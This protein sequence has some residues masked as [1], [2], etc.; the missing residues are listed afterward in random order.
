MVAG[1]NGRKTVEAML[2]RTLKA[3]VGLPLIAVGDWNTDMKGSSALQDWKDAADVRCTAVSSDGSRECKYDHVF[4]NHLVQSSSPA[5]VEPQ[6]S[7]ECVRHSNCSAT[8]PTWFS[9]HMALS[10]DLTF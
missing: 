5:K 3:N 1:A 10:V 2:N 8:R 7:A 9:D 4:C 6:T